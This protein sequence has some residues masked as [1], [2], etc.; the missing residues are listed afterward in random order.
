MP[1][2]W[3]EI[4]SAVVRVL[5]E[6][7]SSELMFNARIVG[8]FEV[9][10]S[11]R[12]GCPLAPLLFAACT[13]PLIAS[14]EQAA[15]NNEIKGL[16][17][18]DGKH[19]LAKMFADDSLLFLQAEKENIRRALEIVQNFATASGSQCSIEKS[20]LISLTE[21]NSFDYAGWTGEVIRKGNIVRHLGIPLGMG[22]S[23]KQA[24][25]WTLE[26]IKRKL[27]RWEFSLLPFH[28]RATVINMFMIPCIMFASPFLQMSKK[29]WNFFL[30]PVKE[31]L[32]RNKCTASRPWQ[33]GKWSDIAKPK[34]QGGLGILDP[35]QH[36]IA[37]CTKFVSAL[38]ESEESWATM[39]RQM[40]LQSKMKSKGG[41]WKI[42]EVHNKLLSPEVVDTKLGGFIGSLVR[43][44][45]QAAS[46]LKWKEE[47]RY[48]K[49]SVEH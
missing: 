23:Q 48:W 25:D 17:L 1:R 21:A 14:L 32:W 7:S 16:L 18:K 30:R 11:I 37:L 9:K 33:W 41:S 36:Q 6:G 47:T 13:H 3:T 49:R 44:C 34:E 27:K 38:A 28:S 4:L 29:S 5:G 26:K 2:L 43:R 24:V 8:S 22:T 40:L 35:T 19:L 20:R 31:F 42:L 10:R 46:T 15:A 45:R 12:Q 39:A